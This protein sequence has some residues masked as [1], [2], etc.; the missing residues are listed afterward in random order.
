MMSTVPFVDIGH[1]AQFRAFDMHNDR[2]LKL[3]LTEAETQAVARR[4]RNIIHGTLEEIASLE[5]RVQTFMNSKARIPAMITHD[6]TNAADFLQL[7]GNPHLESASLLPED[8]PIKKW[9]PARVIY[10][11]D[12]VQIVR[13]LLTYL[14]DQPSVAATDRKKFKQLLSDY[15]EH[16]YAMW[17]FGY[18]DYIFKLGDLGIDPKGR[19]VTVDLGEFTSDLSFMERAVSE[20]WWHDNANHLKTDFPKMPKELEKLYLGMID[21]AFTVDELRKH[22]RTTH[23]CSSCSKETDTLA[24]F[25]STQLAEIDYIDRL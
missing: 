19:I 25:I 22:W 23:H 1:G 8:T 7:M 4:R 6:F 12:K 11:Q 18:S 21:E 15:I 20:K 3:P 16:V 10:T 13:N 17:G 14:C 5:V 2:V 9:G 24:A